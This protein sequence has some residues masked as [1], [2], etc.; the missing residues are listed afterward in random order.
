MIQR[1]LSKTIVSLSKTFPVVSVMG[2][3]QS[4]KTTLVKSLFPKADYISF[5][6]PDSR[7]LAEKD[8][9]GFLKQHD[10]MLIIDEVQRVPHIFSYIQ[11]HAD[12]KRKAG[13]YIFTG[14]QN[15]LLMQNVTQSLAG[16][17]AIVKLFPL[18]MK[19]LTDAGYAIGKLE[20]VLFKGFYPDV[21]NTKSNPAHLYSSYIETYLQRDVRQ[22][23]NLSNLSAFQRFLKLVAARAGQILN[24]S[25]LGNDCG[26]THIT[27]REWMSVLESSFIVHLL[28]P[29]FENFNK[30]IVKSPKIFF[31][32]TGL[33]CNL[34][35]ITEAK[36]L[37]NHTHIGALVENLVFSE[38]A[39]AAFNKG[40]NPDLY[41]WRDKSGNEIDFLLRK[42][43]YKILIEVKAG[44]TVNSD[45]FKGLSYYNKISKDKKNRYYLIY[46]GEK[47]QLHQ[48]V[49]ILNWKNTDEITGK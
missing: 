10:K 31:Y 11:T 41:F 22:I 15:Y 39:K 45:F 36:G 43:L 19:E 5:E 4:G 21:F 44:H 37:R 48:G 1:T 33:L 26:I 49:K 7:A 34:L 25:S 14:S 3:R 47:A 23:K 35:G 29:Y 16:R 42:S 40:L 18:S 32:D 27:A 13:Q 12:E 8:P 9:R 30:R 2:P 20:D 28:P 6:D 38:L 17:V 24:L 46:G